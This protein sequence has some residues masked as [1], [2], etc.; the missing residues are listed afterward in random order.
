MKLLNLHQQL[1]VQYLPF[2]LASSFLTACIGNTASSQVQA[3]SVNVPLSI[4]ESGGQIK[5]YAYTSAG[6]GAPIQTVIDTGSDVYYISRNALGPNVIFTTESVT[7]YYD[8]GNRQVPGVLAYAPVS[9][10]AG[11]TPVLTTTSYSPIVVVESV[12]PPF[13]ALMGVGMRGNLS[14]DLFFPYPYN[15]AI[16]IN[17]PESV[18]SFGLFESTISSSGASFVQLES[19][20]CNNYGTP[21]ESG[22]ANCWNTFGLPIQSTFNSGA[23]AYTAPIM[24][25]VLDTGSDSGFQL[26]PLPSYMDIVG[27]YVTNFAYATL[28]TSSGNLLMNMTNIIYAAN[29]NYNGG[30]FVNV[31]NNVFNYYQIIFNRYDGKVWFKSPSTP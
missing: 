29:S 16:S 5:Y 27:G 28:Q 7:L 31:G 1:R 20:V 9:M 30:N 24:N 4:S 3:Q 14:P 26:M 11:T 23:S 12:S 13:N 8:F 22:S 21:I 2:I 6:G 18:V 17:L 10:Y 19:Q 25:G 15:Q